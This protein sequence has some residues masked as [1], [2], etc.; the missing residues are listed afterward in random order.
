MLQ[1]SPV[2]TGYYLGVDIG[3]VNA[4]LTLVSE[5]G[6]VVEFDVEINIKA[7]N[8]TNRERIQRNDEGDTGID[9]DIL[10]PY[11]AHH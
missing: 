6:R 11:N 5:Y 2:Q 4:K 10:I 7:E 9:R 3:S 8:I 1:L